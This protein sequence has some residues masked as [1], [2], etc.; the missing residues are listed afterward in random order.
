MKRDHV[1]VKIGLEMR[2]GLVKEIILKRGTKE[3]YD[4]SNDCHIFVSYILFQDQKS[5]FSIW[6]HIKS[7]GGCLPITESK[8]EWRT[9][10][11]LFETLYFVKQV[12]SSYIINESHKALL[13]KKK[14]KNSCYL[15][16]LS[17]PKWVF[18]CIYIYIY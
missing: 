16:F 4:P 1:L 18:A 13:R 10:L 6:R 2:F 9:I 17:K 3:S 7:E 15:V 5:H 12:V 8:Y 14:K 11:Y